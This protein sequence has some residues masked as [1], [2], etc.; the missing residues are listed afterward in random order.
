MT[1]VRR[2]DES[3][4]YELRLPRIVDARVRERLV[5][6]LV[7]QLP[8]HEVLSV[9]RA[10]SEGGFVARI[11]LGEREASALLRELY[12]A[13]AEPAVVVLRPTDV[14]AHGRPAEADVA[15]G[16][17]AERR[18]RFVPTWNWRAFV[19][20]PLWYLRKGLY[21]KGLVLLA[22]SVCPIWTL[23]ITLLISLV[24]LVYCG[25]VGNWDRYLWKV[26]RTQWW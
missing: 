22:L 6:V 19:F 9:V 5:N 24:V 17:F 11:Q 3:R 12:A 4:L 18:G 25:V 14:V 2:E 1:P 26:E 10:L 8:A 23:Q 13:G 20:G 21:G 15:F 7:R 16:V